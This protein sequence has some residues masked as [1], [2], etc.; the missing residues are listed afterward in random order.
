MAGIEGDR[1]WTASADIRE[2]FASFGHDAMIEAIPLPEPVITQSILIGKNVAITLPIA[3]GS[4]ESSIRTTIRKGLPQ[5]S[6]A[7][8]FLATYLIRDVLDSV[9]YDAFVLAYTDNIYGAFETANGAAAMLDTLTKGL[10][11]HPLGPYEL[12]DKM[13]THSDHG[14]EV[15]GYFLKTHPDA[16]SWQCSAH[17]AKATLTRFYDRLRGTLLHSDPHELDDLALK[18]GS[19]FISS[20]NVWTPSAQ[21]IDAF[22]AR[23]LKIAAEVRAVKPKHPVPLAA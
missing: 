1:P 14:I 8:N 10:L 21:R 23:S 4:S 22:H 2:F 13:V 20:R 3:Y 11:A 9:A 5:G 6:P 19:Q 16:E 15:L 17:P 7:S 12:K 18:R